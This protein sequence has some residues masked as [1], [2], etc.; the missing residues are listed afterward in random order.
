MEA[1]VSPHRALQPGQ[2]QKA[3]ARVPSGEDQCLTPNSCW[4]GT[5]ILQCYGSIACT[6]LYHEVQE[7]SGIGSG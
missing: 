2:K 6:L 5:L 3:M 4:Q 1:E 7:S